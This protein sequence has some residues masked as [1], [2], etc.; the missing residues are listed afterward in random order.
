MSDGNNRI[1]ILFQFLL[2]VLCATHSLFRCNVEHDKHLTIISGW[3]M[4]KKKLF[5]TEISDKVSSA[6]HENL[7]NNFFL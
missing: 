1:P 7:E 4:K 2:D 5:S 3:R 6:H